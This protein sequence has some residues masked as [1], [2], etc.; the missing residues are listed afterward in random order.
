MEP[1]HIGCY[2]R[3]EPRL[4]GAGKFHRLAAP[5]EADGAGVQGVMRQN[6]PDALLIGQAV[7]DQC[8]I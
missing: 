8:Q 5:G 4:G 7:F 6:E 1:S 3:I 2:K